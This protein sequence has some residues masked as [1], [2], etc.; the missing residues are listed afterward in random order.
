MQSRQATCR[1]SSPHRIVRI[2]RDM[3]P[4]SPGCLSDDGAYRK[5]CQERS[6]TSRQMLRFTSRVVFYRSTVDGS[7]AE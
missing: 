1:R 4:C 2:P 6:S 7:H 5:I 3:K